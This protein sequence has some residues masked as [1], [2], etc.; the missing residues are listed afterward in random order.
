MTRAFHALCLLALALPASARPRGEIA[1][2]EPKG[3]AAPLLYTRST[4]PIFF[5]WP[6]EGMQLS[7][8]GEFILGSVIAATAPFR[9]NG[10]TIA[11]HPDG[12][13]LAWLPISAGTFTFRGELDLSTYT[14]VL[15]RRI[16]VP[17]PVPFKPGKT[18]IDPLSLSPRAELELRAGDWLVARMR[19][20]PGK[21]ARFRVG[22]GDW[23]DMRE[24]APGSYEGVRQIEPG[25]EFEAAQL[26]Y[27]L[28][29]GWGGQKLKGSARVSATAKAPLIATVKTTSAGFISAKTG[30]NNGFLAFP[31]PGTRLQVT[32]RDNGA[33]RV[34]LSEQVSGWVDAKDVDVASGPAPRAVT[35]TVSVVKTD[36]GASVKIGLSERAAFDIEPSED[37]GALTL[38]LHGAV[39][40]T[41]WIINDAQ[42]FVREIRWRQET[43]DV[44]SFKIILKDGERLWGWWPTHDGGALKLDLRRVPRIASRNVF[45]GVRIMLDPGH[46]PSATGSTGPLGT[47]EMDANYAI[48]IAAKERL[49]RAG[50]TVLMTRKDPLDEVSL[51]DRP[52][53]AV[54][55]GA[56]IFVSLHNNALPDGENPFSKPRG[57]TVF[58]YHPQSLELARGVHEAFKSRVKLADEGLR[59]GNLAVNRQS[60]MPA[61][62]VEN[63]YM[64]FPDQEAKLNDPAFRAELARALTD[65]IE[66]FLVQ[67]RRTR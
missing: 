66:T 19:G 56:D 21:P 34:R 7:A 57:F 30:P 37:L 50:A 4:E 58:Y 9:I 59:W 17:A 48:A 67:T 62:L 44:V 35:G 40:H 42:D 11:V 27:E 12:G 33:L 43:T 23:R 24:T 1:L 32:G 2:E 51:V 54:E 16:L 38:R 60:A 45:A 31:L 36:A 47:K 13:F 5:V 29:S 63:A 41:N 25:E 39:G 55:R 20:T 14:A 46:M 8:D 10:T 61:I 6:P 22:K 3:Q 28:G 53:Q 15:E 64:I 52:R 18:E 26:E 65:G 49:E